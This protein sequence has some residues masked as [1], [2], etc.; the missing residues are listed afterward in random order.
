MAGPIALHYTGIDEL[1]QA[2]RAT[3]AELLPAL[4]Q[5]FEKVGDVVRDDAR[6]RLT[7]HFEAG[8]SR[9]S[10]ESI[11]RTAEGF[12]TQVRGVTTGRAVRVL[13]GQTLRKKT[14]RRGDW[15]GEQMRFGLVPA[16]DAK[17]DDAAEA[18][19]A[20]AFGLLHRNGL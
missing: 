13:V 3:D 18:L 6:E 5:E 8:R 12:Q 17:L 9:R 1:I 14:G 20:G 10:A 16:R 15:G 2:L 11:R 4:K 7:A 19:E